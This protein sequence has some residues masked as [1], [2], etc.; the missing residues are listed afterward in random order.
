MLTACS[1]QDITGQRTTKV[2]STL[3]YIEQRVNS[4]VGI[5]GAQD[6]RG[7]P[8]LDIKAAEPDDAPMHAHAPEPRPSQADIDAIFAGAGKA[9]ARAA[10]RGA[11]PAS[12]SPSASQS[13][14]D[15]LFGNQ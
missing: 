8:A 13:Q 2:V 10:D 11:A 15:A 3:H 14:I 4:M 12:T 1:F 6:G 7:V 9:G 5:W